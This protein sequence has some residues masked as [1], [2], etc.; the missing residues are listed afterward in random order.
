MQVLDWLRRGH[1]FGRFEK[2]RKMQVVLRCALQKNLAMSQ[3]LERVKLWV[4]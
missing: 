3:S 1:L 2:E 4:I